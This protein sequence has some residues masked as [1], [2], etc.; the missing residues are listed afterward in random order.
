M[1]IDTE[2]LNRSMAMDTPQVQFFVYSLEEATTTADWCPESCIT[3]S[4]DCLWGDEVVVIVVWIWVL[5]VV[6]DFR[7]D[8]V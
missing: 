5:I 6:I 8:V 1:F 4:Y 3:L 7:R 2:Q